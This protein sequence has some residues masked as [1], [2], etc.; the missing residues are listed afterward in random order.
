MKKNVGTTDRI[1][2][3]TVGIIGLIIA[4]VYKN[5]FIGIVSIIVLLT[6]IIG[7]CGLYTLFGINT[8][9]VNI[10]NNNN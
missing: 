9:K 5:L 2:R 6:G 1:I 3:I 8:C 4:L 7:F 10:K